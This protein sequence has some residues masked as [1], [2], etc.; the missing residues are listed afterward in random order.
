MSVLQHGKYQR[1]Q[2]YSSQSA[3]NKEHQWTA[4][5]SSQRDTSTSTEKR[6]PQW[7][8]YDMFVVFLSVGWVKNTGIKV[9]APWW[10]TNVFTQAAN[11]PKWRLWDIWLSFIKHDASPQGG[12][13]RMRPVWVCVFVLE[14]LY[15]C[16]YLM[17]GQPSCVHQQEVKPQLTFTH[18]VNARLHWQATMSTAGDNT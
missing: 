13:V 4:F 11:H 16:V 6:R 1:K 3:N 18:W 12:W 2:I 15:L 9:P 8:G 5:G 17:S 10:G 7:N 14:Y